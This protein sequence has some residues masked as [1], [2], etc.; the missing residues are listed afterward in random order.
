MSSSR[1]RV[2]SCW[3]SAP[4]KAVEVGKRDG[5]VPARA[6]DLDLGAKSSQRYVHVGRVRGDAGLWALGAFVGLAQN[7][8]DAVEAL[9]GGATGAR[10]TLVACRE[11][12][13]HEVVAT[14]ALK[15]VAAGC[16]HVTQLRRGS[17]EEGFGDQGVILD[18]EWMVGEIGVA[19]EGAY[20]DT[21]VL[22]WCYVGEGVEVIDVDEGRGG[23]GAVFHKVEEIGAAGEE[24]GFGFGDCMKGDLGL[25]D[26][27]VVEGV[28][29]ADP[30]EAAVRTAA[31][32]LG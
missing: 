18:D 27:L 25:E 12:R 9:D 14:R 30:R 23:L 22:G 11:G 1:V 6:L 26:T 8:V 2:V 4:W 32:M 29:E 13:V 10:Y 16:G 21:T 15:E 7:G 3:G 17:A 19:D 31:T 20:R 28:H 24:L 5:A